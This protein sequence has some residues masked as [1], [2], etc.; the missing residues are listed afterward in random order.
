MTLYEIDAQLNVALNAALKES[1]DGS[2]PEDWK[3]TIDD[4]KMEREEK[5]LAVA[6]YRKNVKA[7]ADA[8]KAEKAKLAAR[9]ATLDR[10]IANLDEYLT[11]ILKDGEKM[12]NG[13]TR[14]SWRKSEKLIISNPEIITSEWYTLEKKFKNFDMKQAIKSGESVDG[15]EIQSFNNLQIK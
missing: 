13:N 2:I 3:D 4:I 11:Y 10:K 14:I 15:A 9:Q 1:E 8:V 5:A 6:A 7:W 12:Q